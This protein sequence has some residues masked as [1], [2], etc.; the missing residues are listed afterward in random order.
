MRYKD[1]LSFPYSL[2]LLLKEKEEKEECYET[3]S[4]RH[5]VV[6][7]MSKIGA[8]LNMFQEYDLD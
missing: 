8:E 3:K 6:F 5:V 7:R 1:L 4:K 2:Y